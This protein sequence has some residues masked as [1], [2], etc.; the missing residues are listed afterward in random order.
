M[1][2]AVI[3]EDGICDNNR[4][5]IEE[6]VKSGSTGE[7]PPQNSLLRASGAANREEHVRADAE[8]GR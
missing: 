2:A 1:S 4:R 8:I 3:E 5:T 6:R 7:T